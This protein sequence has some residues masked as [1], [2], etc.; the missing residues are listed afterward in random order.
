[1]TKE[2]PVIQILDKNTEETLE[3]ISVEDVF[4]VEQCSNGIIVS[5]RKFENGNR[6][7]KNYVGSIK[8]YFSVMIRC[9]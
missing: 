4:T 6:I 3:I 9:N 7:V 2:I 5:F 8:L 1:M